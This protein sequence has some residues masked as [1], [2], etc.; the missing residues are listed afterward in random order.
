M[1]LSVHRHRSESPAVSHVRYRSRSADGRMRVDRPKQ[2]RAVPALNHAICAKFF[3]EREKEHLVQ[4]TTDADVRNVTIAQLHMI[5]WRKRY[6]L[7]EAWACLDELG[8]VNLR[9]TGDVAGAMIRVCGERRRMDRIEEVLQRMDGEPMTDAT[10]AALVSVYARAGKTGLAE[11]WYLKMRLDRDVKPGFHACS[12]LIESLCKTLPHE[13][14]RCYHEALAADPDKVL[15]KYRLRDVAIA[16]S[17]SG[18]GTLA[19]QVMN[20]LRE[21]PGSAFFCDPFTYKAVME[22]CLNDKIVDG[23]S[24][25]FRTFEEMRVA[26]GADEFAFTLALQACAQQK[27]REGAQK[28]RQLFNEMQA[29]DIKP[30]VHT[31]HKLIAALGNGGDSDHAVLCVFKACEDMGRA[32]V[33]IPASICHELIRALANDGGALKTLDVLNAMLKGQHGLPQ[34]SVVTYSNVINALLGDSPGCV[35]DLVAKM[36]DHLVGGLDTLH[37]NVVLLACAKVSDGKTALHFFRRMRE[38]GCQCDSATYQHVIDACDKTGGMESS[39]DD[40]FRQ[41]VK[42]G[43]LKHA[44]HPRL[45]RSAAAA[46]I[47]V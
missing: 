8:S 17:K 42:D 21:R 20:Q 13:A 33:E 2:P 31:L 41:G 40:V 23:T 6:S 45:S 37:W 4:R 15:N 25:A 26:W 47:W 1:H 27:S 38:A 14:V 46:R 9:V 35:L 10:Y 19:V 44:Q 16:C 22:A 7:D 5:A 12:S 29:S 30:T 18:Y 24:A 28:A 39:I 32:G 3:A 11:A 34:P 43:I 36:P